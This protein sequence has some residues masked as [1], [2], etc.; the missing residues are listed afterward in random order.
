MYIDKLHRSRVFSLLFWL[1]F[2]KNIVQLIA[3]YWTELVFFL[4]ECCWFDN[5]K[6]QQQYWEAKQPSPFS[7]LKKE[8]SISLSSDFYILF[9][10]WQLSADSFWIL[11]K[12]K[13]PLR[14]TWNCPIFTAENTEISELWSNNNM[15][16]VDSV[17]IV[18]NM[19]SNICLHSA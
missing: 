7:T 5:N 12:L 6:M 14:C 13:G 8:F 3:L 9:H 2:M 18:C 1:W 4:N 11:Q 10:H 16:T 17:C 19:F 15:H